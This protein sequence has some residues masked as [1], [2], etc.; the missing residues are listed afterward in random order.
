MGMRAI[1]CSISFLFAVFC[2]AE[3]KDGERVL[4]SSL[5]AE[6]ENGEVSGLR[7]KLR[8]RLTSEVSIVGLPKNVFRGQI[9]CSI[10]SEFVP[11]SD[12]EYCDRSS[13]TIIYS[14]IVLAPGESI[15]YFIPLHNL[16]ATALPNDEDFM[17]LLER[18]RKIREKAEEEKGRSKNVLDIPYFV[19]NSHLF[20]RAEVSLRLV[21]LLN[22]GKE[23]EL[24]KIVTKPRKIVRKMPGAR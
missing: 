6:K 2:E 8:N 13:M 5:L 18:R 23:N 14:P 21:F 16:V 9:V 3:E 4:A 15:E 24:Y 19:P 7:I 22:G 20:D 1:A 10:G 11:F 17:R 12:K